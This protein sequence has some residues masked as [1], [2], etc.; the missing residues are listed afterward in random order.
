M[1]TSLFQQ[2]KSEESINKKLEILFYDRSFRKLIVQLIFSFFM[3][4]FLFYLITRAFSLDLG[5]GHLSSRAGFG[6]SHT[7]LT[8]YSSNDSRWQ[9]YFVG[10]INTIR[11]S[12]IGILLATT[13]GVFMGLA[14]L[15][16]NF[17]INK[18]S[19]GYV[20]FI[21]N[22]P[23]LIQI[24]FWQ[25]VLL[26]LPQISDALTFGGLS[27]WSNRGILLPFVNSLENGSLWFLIILISIIVSLILRSYLNKYRDEN[28]NFFSPSII[29]FV[30]FISIA[31]ITYFILGVDLYTDVP[32]LEVNEYGTY[33]QSGGFLL[34]PEFAA[35]LFALVLYTGTFITEIVRGS[36]QSL[37]KGQTEAAQAL[38]FSSYQRITLIILPQALRSIIP[39]LTNQ[40][41]NLTKNSSLS[42]AI[43][44]P[45]VFMVSR[46]IMNNAGHALP[47][48]SLILVTFLGL[49]LFISLFMNFLNRRVTRIGA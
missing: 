31:S 34:S 36:I 19:A 13:L 9:A 11:V 29:S 43:A 24:I 5:F 17:L 4:L 25:L 21:R 14:R 7:F 35:I 46:T 38:G 22:T 44:Y 20:E 6:I 2:L 41:L 26:Q 1:F 33:I 18:I 45:D 10:I 12:F 28:V 49:S 8:D 27:V 42:V 39:P 47:M 48:L 37:P 23:L 16:K 30:F 15:S 40:Y 3:I 32:S